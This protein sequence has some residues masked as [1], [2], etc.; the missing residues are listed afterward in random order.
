MLRQFNHLTVTHSHHINQSLA[1][2]TVKLLCRA[3]FPARAQT[4]A[5]KKQRNC[6]SFADYPD[7]NSPTLR[8]TIQEDLTG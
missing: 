8:G 3:E 2:L 6:F 1:E 4:T 5:N 7:T